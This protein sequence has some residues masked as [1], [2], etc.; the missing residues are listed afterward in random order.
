MG[1]GAI[2]NHART[3]QKP[4]RNYVG[5]V[6]SFSEKPLRGT[7]KGAEHPALG[8]ALQYQT[9]LYI[10]HSHIQQILQFPGIVYSAKRDK[11][12]RA[13]D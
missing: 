13:H 1:T 7:R 6:S 12:V 8:S 5:F 4:I 10:K 3:E 2:G 11:N 9:H